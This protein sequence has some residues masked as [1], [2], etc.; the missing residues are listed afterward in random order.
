MIVLIMKIR[1]NMKVV[2]LAKKKKVRKKDELNKYLS[3]IKNHRAKL[4][5]NEAS[6]GTQVANYQTIQDE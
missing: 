5:K 3:G 6:G 1:V 4:I 2:L